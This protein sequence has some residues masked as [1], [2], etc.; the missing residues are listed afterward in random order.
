[1]L[2][3]LAREQKAETEKKEYCQT[4]LDRS[5]D[6]KKGIEQDLSDL[7][8]AI[9]DGQNEVNVLV[10]EIDALVTGI[11]QL[12]TSVAEATGQN[13]VNVLVE[14]IDALVTGIKQLD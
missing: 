6:E 3:Q 8:V 2:K 12:D 9:A 10:E 1:M 4:E 13:E 11:K 7:D 14:E 5:A